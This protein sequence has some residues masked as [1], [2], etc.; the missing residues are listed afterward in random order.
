MA[1]D[2]VRRRVGDF[3]ARHIQSNPTVDDIKA[4]DALL[5]A[6]AAVLRGLGSRCL[7][8]GRKAFRAGHHIEGRR[9]DILA[10]QLEQRADE[11]ERRNQP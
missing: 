10:R 7:E 4:L 11:V 3:F 2:T 9:L 5:P 6:D 8:E 1:D